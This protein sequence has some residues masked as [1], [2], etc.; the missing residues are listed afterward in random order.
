MTLDERGLGDTN[1][2]ISEFADITLPRPR[3]RPVGSDDAT[4]GDAPRRRYAIIG[5][6]GYPSTYGGFETFVRRFAPYLAERGVDVTVYG[7][8]DSRPEPFVTPDGVRVVN[9]RGKDTKCASTLSYGLTACTH[10]ARERYDAALVLNCANG[11]WL[12]LLRSAGVPT[13]VNVDG[14][15]WER[16]K[17]SSLGKKV[18]RQGAVVTS[19]YADRLISDARGIAD[20][21]QEH[22]DS[23]STVI[24]Y[25]GDVLGPIPDTKVR[26]QGLEPGRYILVVARL[27]PENNVELLLDAVQKLGGRYRTVVVGSAVGDAPIETRLR[28]MQRTD[29]VLWLGHVSDQDLL[30]QLWQHCGVY[31]HGHSVGGTNPALLQ[32]LGAGSPTVAFDT[33]FNRE[34]VREAC[35]TY[36]KDADELAA[37]LVRVMN[38]DLFRHRLSAAGQEIIRQ[39]YTWEQV[40]AD[41]L[42]VLDDLAGIHSR[43]S[44]RAIRSAQ[45]VRRLVPASR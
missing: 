22:F 26:E 25:G 23:D 43:S 16:D 21:W 42:Q 8:D 20:Y 34:V 32:A 37:L 6:R 14:L 41:Y 13:A 10:A 18:F 36:G 24:P 40:C 38:D 3:L 2:L 29:N 1:K 15:E 44:S 28:E 19:K 45:R 30:Q 35:P 7:R 9:T 39:R 27:V 17:W 5:S 12:P 31:V 11:Y 4:R 33:V